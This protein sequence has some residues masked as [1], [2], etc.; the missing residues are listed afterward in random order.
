MGSA[1]AKAYRDGYRTGRTKT[2]EG[3]VEFSA[4]QVRDTTEPFA[5]AIRNGKEQFAP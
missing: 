3:M 1:E 2:A 4:P 5:S